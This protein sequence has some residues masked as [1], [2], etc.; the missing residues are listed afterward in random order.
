MAD[1][2]SGGRT[3]RDRAP[4]QSTDSLYFCLSYAPTFRSSAGEGSPVG[5]DPS[6]VAFFHDLSDRVRLVLG[7]A[8]G[9]EVGYLPTPEPD[10]PWPGRATAPALARCKI[11]VPLYCERYFNND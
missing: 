8:P 9:T 1:A 11:L 3:A 4:S 6:V 5:A 10:E 2:S 7:A